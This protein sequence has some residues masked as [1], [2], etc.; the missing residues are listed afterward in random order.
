MTGFFTFKWN[1]PARE[2]YVTGTFDGWGQSTKLE[3]DGDAFIAKVKLPVAKTLYKF[4]VDGNW[5]VDQSARKEFDDGNENN[6]L[7]P[8]DIEA[9]QQETDMSAATINSAAPN[10]TTAALAAA[11]PVEHITNGF[12]HDETIS[13]VAPES[14][15][16]ELAAQVPKVV[17][18]P[19]PGDVPGGFPET[20]G[21]ETSDPTP[22]TAK[23]LPAS[24]TPT[25]PFHLEPGEPIPQNKFTTADLNKHVKLDEES[26]ERADASSLGFS[27]RGTPVLPE[28]VTPAVLR[29]SE[30]HG[31]LDIPEPTADL[32]PESSLPTTG[33]AAASA[34]SEV[35]EIVKESQEK[36]ST[37]PEA[38]ATP[39]AV[40][41]KKEFEE[42]LKT[43][44][45]VIPDIKANGTT[46]V[47]GIMAAAGIASASGESND[48]T[49]PAVV[50]DIVLDSQKQ[51]HAE[52][53]ASAIEQIVEAKKEFEEELK[54]EVH[55]TAPVT[56][57][58]PI[59]PVAEV[60]AVVQK[61]LAESGGAPE[62]TGV[63]QT[64][65]LK[66]EVEEELKEE[67][68]PTEAVPALLPKDEP[69]EFGYVSVPPVVPS[70]SE[71]GTALNGNT[72][73]AKS[74]K[75]DRYVEVNGNGPKSPK[76]SFEN[77]DGGELKRS[78][79]KGFFATLKE[80]IFHPGTATKDKGKAKGE[81]SPQL[82]SPHK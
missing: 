29:E 12:V 55:L 38:S 17:S 81:I 64:V 69:K 50:P 11:V 41:L 49:T 79:W 30:G 47:G 13:S 73:S 65:E 67:V 35:P 59:Q 1:Y 60:P 6:L 20:P 70:K 39:Q 7:I 9:E 71:N 32:I 33:F 26:Y 53:E 51:A 66:K 45:P 77:G 28:V 16:A 24:D 76:K 78:K 3:K 48:E 19:G 36:A 31:V 61:S 43:E 42:E 40:E 44:V 57:N 74:E 80:R 56:L 75:S 68:K 15:T 37:E 8:E 22:I 63:T 21:V 34:A 58:A 4:I 72:N 5:V 82:E 25:N 54:K 2:V 14:S 18:T 62:A 23:A 27:L 46:T 52:P 10:S